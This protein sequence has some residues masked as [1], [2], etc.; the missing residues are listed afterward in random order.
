[1]LVADFL[2]NM[3]H[4]IRTPLNGIIGYADLALEDK[5]VSKETRRHISRVFEASNSLRVIIDDILEF[6]KIEARGIELELKP[7]R[8]GEL[9]D[10][11][12]SIVKLKANESGL[13][14]TSR[15]D[16]RV[17]AAVIGDTSQPGKGSTFWFEIILPVADPAEMDNRNGP[18]TQSARPLRILSVDDVATNRDLCE[19]ILTRAGHH[20]TLAESGKSA[21]ALAAKQSFDI[22]LMDIQ[23]PGMDGLEASRHIRALGG[24]KGKVPIIAL[25]ANVLPVQVSGYKAAGMDGHIGKPIVKAA[26]LDAQAKWSAGLPPLGVEPVVAAPSLIPVHDDEMLQAL[27]M[28]DEPHLVEGFVSNLRATIDAAPKS[29]RDDAAS[30]DDRRQLAAAA[31]KAVNVAGQ[32]GFAELADVYRTLEA[33]C[34]EDQPVMPVLT[35]LHEAIDR[36]LPKIDNISVVA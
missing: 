18:V 16:D 2:A 22:I 12:A 3:S 6:F 34:L 19:A 26:L 27:R 7:F 29:W 17:P 24:D 8:P 9:A 1:M 21:I 31:H 32:L 5:S 14:V 10:N 13:E 15:L 11:C 25:T 33:I 28:M 20:V 23:M 36:A 30:F 4:E 35:R